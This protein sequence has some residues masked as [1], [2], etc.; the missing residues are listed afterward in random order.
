[1]NKIIYIVIALMT[2][3]LPDV[4]GQEYYNDQLTIENLNISKEGDVINIS[5]DVNLNNLK[6][7]KNEM[8]IVTPV[9]LSKET[10]DAIELVPFTV[11][12]KLRN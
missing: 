7:N 12:G 5:M 11:I 3:T 9:I 8:L 10:E 4:F 6:L 1:M 2:I